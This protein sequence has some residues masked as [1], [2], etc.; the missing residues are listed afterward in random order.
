MILITRY[1]NIFVYVER[2]NVLFCD[3]YV[4]KFVLKALLCKSCI[5]RI[6]PLER[7]VNS[8]MRNAL[9]LF[10]LVM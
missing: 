4:E 3:F 9:S 5:C 6:F 10:I 7:L 8:N 2:E 1:C